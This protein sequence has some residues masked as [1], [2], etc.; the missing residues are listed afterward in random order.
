MI[1]VRLLPLLLLVAGCAGASRIDPI[2]V[3]PADSM[4][5][6]LVFRGE[7]TTTVDHLKVASGTLIGQRVPDTPGGL[8]PIIMYPMSTVDSVTEAHLDRKALTYTLLPLAVML[9][10]ALGFR[11]G[12]GSD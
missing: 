6:F 9:A 2:G 11:A 7:R 12:Y 10:L 3:A 5:A 4:R 8:R 1:R